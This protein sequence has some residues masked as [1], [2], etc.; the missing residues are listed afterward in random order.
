MTQ[1]L[2]G[3]AAVGGLTAAGLLTGY[4]IYAGGITPGLE[5]LMS[6]AG[7]I[8]EKLG[9]HVNSIG[10]FLATAGTN[11]MQGLSGLKERIFAGLKIPTAAAEGAAQ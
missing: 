10:G 9:G 2:I 5:L 1:G 7:P 6:H 11:A 8:A 3:T 4:S